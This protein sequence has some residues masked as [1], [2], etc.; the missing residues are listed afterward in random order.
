MLTLTDSHIPNKLRVNNLLSNS[1]QF[2]KLYNICKFDGMWIEPEERI[3]I[4]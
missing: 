2:I 4:F 3:K 1:D